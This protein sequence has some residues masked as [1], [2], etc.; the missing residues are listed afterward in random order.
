MTKPQELWCR[1]SPTADMVVLLG[2]RSLD[3]GQLESLK[4]VGVH[5]KRATAFVLPDKH[6]DYRGLPGGRGKGEGAY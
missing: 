6:L 1:H 5:S 4:E 3:V 2:C